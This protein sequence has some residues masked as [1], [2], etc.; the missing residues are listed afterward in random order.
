MRYGC[1]ESEGLP[2]GTQ[3][4][5]LQSLLDHFI[6]GEYALS[7]TF[8]FVCLIVRLSDYIF[9]PLYSNVSRPTAVA[10]PGGGGPGGPDPPPPLLGQDVGFLPMGPKVSTCT[11]QV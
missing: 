3:Q 1:L 5:A 6:S 9:A 4:T 8:P 11:S 10:D 2:P 7:F